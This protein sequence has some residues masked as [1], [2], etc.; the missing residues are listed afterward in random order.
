VRVVPVNWA[1]GQA[2][3]PFQVVATVSAT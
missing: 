3:L 2:G 1:P